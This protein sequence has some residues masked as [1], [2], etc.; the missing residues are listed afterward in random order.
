MKGAYQHT[1]GPNRAHDV[2]L[3]AHTTVYRC[4]CARSDGL[5][6]E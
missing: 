2:K 4:V 1:V 5:R 3:R 6:A